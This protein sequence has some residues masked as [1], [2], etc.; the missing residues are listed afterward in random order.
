MNQTSHSYLRGLKMSDFK[1]LLGVR[2]SG[3]DLF[4]IVQ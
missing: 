1:I 4:N 2:Y 3:I